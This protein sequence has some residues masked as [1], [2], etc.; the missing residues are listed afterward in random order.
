MSERITLELTLPEYLQLQSIVS[1]TQEIYRERA[2]ALN[3][4]YRRRLDQLAG[5]V[6]DAGRPSAG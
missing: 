3:A 6:N 2:T 1:R 5:V 4:G